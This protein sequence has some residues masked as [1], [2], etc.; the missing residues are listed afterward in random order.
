MITRQ[1]PILTHEVISA[2]SGGLIGTTFFSRQF[3]WGQE[4]GFVMITRTGAAPTGTT[5]SLTP[6]LQISD[7]GAAFANVAAGT[8]ISTATTQAIAFTNAQIATAVTSYNNTHTYMRSEEHTSE[9]QSR[10]YLVC[11][12]LLEK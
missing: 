9:L 11:R 4:P 8:A 6:T 7:N 2:A 5:P 1:E 3:P 10:Q 12:L